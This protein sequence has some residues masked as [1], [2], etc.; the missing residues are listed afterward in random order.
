MISARFVLAPHK[1]QVGE[2]YVFFHALLWSFFPIVSILSFATIAPLYAA[3]FSA[4][5]AGLFL[6]GVITVR[7]EWHYVR[8]REAWR[9]MVFIIATNAV[10]FYGLVFI[11]LHY[12]TAGNAAI[13]GLMEI[14]FTMSILGRLGKE[15]YG[16]LTVVGT[17]M[18]ALGA[19]IVLSGASYHFY[20]GDILM[21]LATAIPPI[22]NY[23]TRRARM[24]V[25]ATYIL[26]MRSLFGGFLLFCIALL[27]SPLPTAPEV[28]SVLP[29]LIINGVLFLGLAK[30]FWIESIHRIS[31]A[32]ALGLGSV[33]PALTLLFAYLILHEVPT[34]WQLAGI[35]P[36]IFGAWLLTRRQPVGVPSFVV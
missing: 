6:L 27:F 35:V 4:F 8:I 29:F 34:V 11:A 25:S 7:K 15:F 23:F 17:V 36:M 31:I 2:Y 14:F 1:E 5:W 30:V 13:L 9:D 26:C 24:L 19:L 12:T 21:V 28:Y 33:A 32:K 16:R 20:L 22:G 18:M 10:A 3:A